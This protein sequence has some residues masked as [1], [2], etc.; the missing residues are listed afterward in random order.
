ME[1][2]LPTLIRIQK[3]DLDALRLRMGELENR[4][5]NLRQTVQRLNEELS[6][7]LQQAGDLPEMRQFFGNFSE[8]IRK[9]R[10][11]VQEEIMKLDEQMDELSVEI[12]QKFGEL[13]KYEIALENWRK[14]QKAARDRKEQIELDDIGTQ[15]YSRREAE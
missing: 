6:K 9:R 2:A 11:K 14:A 10:K 4:K 7:E 13:K 3:K 12:S 15:I 8:H 1:K 5:E